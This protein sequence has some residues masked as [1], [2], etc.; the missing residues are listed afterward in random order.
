LRFSL[1]LVGGVRKEI[2]LR[3]SLFILVITTALV[4]LTAGVAS[5]DVLTVTH[6][7]DSFPDEQCGFEGTATVTF[8]DVLRETDDQQFFEFENVVGTYVF[9]AE[10]GKSFTIRF[11]GPVFSSPPMIDEQAGTVTF[12]NRVVGLPE[13][14][15]ITHGPTLSLDA[16][17]VTFTV[18]F[19]YTGDPNNPVG[20]FISSD[21]DESSLHGPHPDLVSDFNLFCDVLT[22]YLQDP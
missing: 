9:T 17:T 18:V 5:A 14:I 6:Q 1:S 10:N 22:P 20:E 16:G 8:T 3:R 2:V 19:A 13:K 7:S 12:I 15:S 11:A 4:A 21:F